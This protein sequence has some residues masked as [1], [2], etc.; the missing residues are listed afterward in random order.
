MKS[1]SLFFTISIVIMCL[2]FRADTPHFAIIG[3]W[4]A[5]DSKETYIE[6]VFYKNKK[7]EIVTKDKKQKSD[8]TTEMKYT[9]DDSKSPAWIDLEII[10]K[11]D[12]RMSLKILGIIEIIDENN[13]KMNIGGMKDRP[14]DFSGNNVAAFHRMEKP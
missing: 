7:Y 1:L 12:P 3:R 11:K 8:K 4:A 9:F 10:N 6:Y 14:S 5:T 2:S 13:F